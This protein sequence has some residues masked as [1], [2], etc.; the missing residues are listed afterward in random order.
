MIT[1]LQLAIANGVVWWFGASS[2]ILAS[3]RKNVITAGAG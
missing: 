3:T 1:P 2:V